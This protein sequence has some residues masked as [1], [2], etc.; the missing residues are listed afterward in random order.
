MVRA[1]P[2]AGAPLRGEPVQF[3]SGAVAAPIAFD[4]ATRADAAS[5]GAAMPSGQLYTTNAGATSFGI[6]ANKM[7]L[8]A[9][10]GAY[11]NNFALGGAAAHRRLHAKMSNISGGLLH[12][13]LILSPAYIDD[14]NAVQVIWGYDNYAFTVGFAAQIRYVI[15]GVYSVLVTDFNPANAPANNDELEISYNPTTGNIIV[16]TG[17]NNYYGTLNIPVGDRAA[18]AAVTDMNFAAYNDARDLGGSRF[19]DVEVFNV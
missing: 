12:D 2:I 13:I 10:L 18:F 1:R 6:T 19:D 5:L 3:R 14:N 17:G 11:G 9:A 15:G 4:Y 16:L 7:Q 8:K